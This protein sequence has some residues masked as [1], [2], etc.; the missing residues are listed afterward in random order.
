MTAG[1]SNLSETLGDR[2]I[3]CISPDLARTGG[4]ATLGI[5]LVVICADAMGMGDSVEFPV[6]EIPPSN[7]KPS[8]ARTLLE[9]EAAVAFLRQHHITHLLA[10]KT[11]KRLQERANALGLTLMMGEPSIAQRF[12]NKVHFA[13]ITQE[14]GLSSARIRTGQGNL[15]TH[16]AL[17]GE[18][19]ERYVLQNA[20]GH[21]GQ[22]T[23]R[24]ASQSQHEEAAQAIAH[25]GWRAMRWLEGSTWTLN[26]CVDAHGNIQVG[27]G[28]RQFTGI[29]ACTPHRLGACGNAWGEATPPPALAEMAETLGEALHRAGYI[30]AFGLDA[31]DSESGLHAIEVN[32]RATSGLAM[33]ACIAHSAGLPSIAEAHVRAHLGERLSPTR[34]P[35]GQSASQLVVYA[36]VDNETTLPSSLQSGRYRVSHDTC[37][38]ID[39]CTDPS[40]TAA[41]E[42]ILWARTAER[43][44]PASAEILRIQSTSLL[45][46]SDTNTLTERGSQW[47][48]ALGVP[49]LFSS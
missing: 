13:T 48:R 25:R 38:R 16:E 36:P 2:R 22:G 4:W 8:N 49:A 24:V 19:G 40:L 37:Q 1:Q 28:Y 30:G 18:F 33:E 12:E 47:M 10:F 9:S 15:P 23:W 27:P 39:D 7:G 11:N 20:R 3:A 44:L 46:R 41:D 31:I 14:L 17:S 42:A 35:P 34:L 5:P 32:P 21:S 43:P 26:A 6:L 45:A 29:P